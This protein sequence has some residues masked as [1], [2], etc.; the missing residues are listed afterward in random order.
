MAEIYVNV[1]FRH[2]N[3]ET[4]AELVRLFE[5]G[6][7]GFDDDALVRLA[8]AIN[9]DKGEGIAKAFLHDLR[10]RTR[11]MF[12]F[13]EVADIAGYCC[14]GGT[15][16][17]SGDRFAGRCVRF[18]Y[19]LCPGIDARAWG[20]GDDDPWEFW[21]KHEN[22]HLVRHDAEPFDGHDNRI[23]GT[24]YRWWHDGLPAAIKEGML[25]DGDDIDE[26]ADDDSHVSDA[27]YEN[28]LSKQE[29]GSDFEDDVEEVVMDEIVDA[30]TT[31]LGNLFAGASSR[32]KTARADAFDCEELDEDAV[33]AVF[34]D[35][36]AHEKAFDIDG[37][38]KHISK[39]LKGEVHTTVEGKMTKMPLSHSLYRMSL[40]L[41]LKEDSEYESAGEIEA[42]S[43]DD[44][45]ARV[46]VKSDTLCLDPMTSTR[47]SMSTDDAY[48][49]EI[50][51]G[52]I[53]VTELVSIETSSKAA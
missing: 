10:D 19:N 26:D 41:L 12:D 25:N 4:H 33:R 51:D 17:G 36:E 34:D 13:E 1:Y 21:F 28:W 22:G 53:Q 40:K 15:Y 9:P 3:P 11:E 16:G 45:V 2:E 42:I 32:K 30:F 43:I 5:M 47:I 31:A 44:G 49:L 6:E 37:I 48:T 38:M 8:G 24:I 18:L 46:K 29:A 7:R 27:E 14:A 39:Q 35:I 50:V 20:M 52:K 23:K